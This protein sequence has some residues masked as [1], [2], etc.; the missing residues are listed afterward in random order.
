MCLY[1]MLRAA[2]SRSEKAP[3]APAYDPESDSGRLAYIANHLAEIEQAGALFT[4][5]YGTDFNDFLYRSGL[6]TFIRHEVVSFRYPDPDGRFQNFLDTSHWPEINYLN[7][8]GPFYTGNSDTCGTGEREAP[9]N[10][11]L[12]DHAEE[13][14]FRQP[15]NFTEFLCVLSAAAVEV[16]GSYSCDGN[17][18]WTYQLCRAW[19]QG[20][21]ALIHRLS[22]PTFRKHNGSRVRLYLDYLNGP[23]ETDLRKYCYFLENSRYPTAADPLPPL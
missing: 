7:F 19:W 23:A 14:I 13:Y 9:D 16:L 4:K 5:R 15:Q 8:P 6:A 3:P 21:A 18:R 2:F 1:E 22:T 20:K 17:D 12:T 11:L 10:V